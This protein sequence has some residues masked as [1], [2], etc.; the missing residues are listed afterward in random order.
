MKCRDKA[1][2]DESLN[3]LVLFSRGWRDPFGSLDPGSGHDDAFIMV[4]H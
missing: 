4:S 2:C 1:V 3:G